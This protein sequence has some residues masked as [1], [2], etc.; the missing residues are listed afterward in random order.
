MSV[1]I[2]IINTIKIR[3]SLRSHAI[4]LP[5]FCSPTWIHEGPFPIQLALF[6]G[7]FFDHRFEILFYTSCIPTSATALTAFFLSFS[8]LPMTFSLGPT[9]RILILTEVSPCLDLPHPCLD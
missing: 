4:Y 1:N 2:I 3:T 6:L 9:F 5:P 7:A 8:S